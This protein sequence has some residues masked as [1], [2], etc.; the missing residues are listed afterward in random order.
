MKLLPVIHKVY[1]MLSIIIANLSAL[2]SI[3]EDL[4]CSNKKSTSTIQS[5]LRLHQLLIMKL[6]LKM[7]RLK[8]RAKNPRQGQYKDR[9]G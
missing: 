2:D 3:Q 9:A 4:L 7:Y 6:S 8:R 1:A 5:L